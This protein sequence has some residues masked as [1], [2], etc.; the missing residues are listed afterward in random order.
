V[1]EEVFAGTSKNLRG[2]RPS[3]DVILTRR[4]AFLVVM[5]GDPSKPEIAFG[6]QYFAVATRTL[7]VIQKRLAES[8]RPQAREKLSVNVG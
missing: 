2:G 6:Q 5:N 8:L 7:E 1:P 4:A 3:E